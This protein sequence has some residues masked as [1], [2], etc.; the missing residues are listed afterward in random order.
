MINF[1][2]QEVL[3]FGRQSFI[4]FVDKKNKINLYKQVFK[5]KRLYFLSFFY[6]FTL[7]QSLCF[8]FVIPPSF[9]RSV[10]GYTP[11]SS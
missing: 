8:F 3:L 4:R 7:P 2:L 10:A 5:I 6:S 1:K 11:S 9:I